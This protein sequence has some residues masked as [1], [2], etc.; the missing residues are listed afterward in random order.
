MAFRL[1]PEEAEMGIKPFYEHLVEAVRLDSHPGQL[2]LAHNVQKTGGDD[3]RLEAALVRPYGKQVMTLAP[4]GGGSVSDAGS[5]EESFMRSAELVMMMASDGAPLE[6]ICRRTGVYPVISFEVSG[7]ITY[8][9]GKSYEVS[10]A[11]SAREGDLTVT[12]P[13]VRVVEE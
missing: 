4:G 1:V 12:G 6:H 13:R 8:I 7:R 10:L 9:F 11:S 5:D 2:E 3:I